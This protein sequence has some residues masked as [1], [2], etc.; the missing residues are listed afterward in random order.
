[1]ASP[2]P[3]GDSNP[4]GAKGGAGGY[5]TEMQNLSS[6]ANRGPSTSDIQVVCVSA[7]VA[8][9]AM[10]R[11][12]QPG[13]SVTVMGLPTNSGNVGVSKEGPEGAVSGPRLVCGVNGI[14]YP[15]NVRNLAEIFIAGALNDKINIRIRRG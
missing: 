1:M 13:E 3:E 4:R 8:K 14:E 7:T 2:G 5:V 10:D 11:A 12:M 15:L 6:G 9:Q